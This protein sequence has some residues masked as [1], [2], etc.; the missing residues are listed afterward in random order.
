MR[1]SLNEDIKERLTEQAKIQIVHFFKQSKTA[2]EKY[3]PFA[4]KRE[5]DEDLGTDL[6]SQDGLNQD[7]ATP[8]D[9]D[10]EQ[11]VNRANAK[12]IFAGLKR[13]AVTAIDFLVTPSSKLPGCRNVLAKA[14]SMSSFRVHTGEENN[15]SIEQEFINEKRQS[16]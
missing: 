7:I 9:R 11:R 3:R 16:L 4:T 1:G 12:M 10:G 14:S 13:Q 2:T 5:N 15:Q 8:K 6:S